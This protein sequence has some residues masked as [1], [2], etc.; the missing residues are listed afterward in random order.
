MLLSILFFA[1]AMASTPECGVQMQNLPTDLAKLG[2]SI[3]GNFTLPPLNIGEGFIYADDDG[4]VYYQTK[5]KKSVIV[6]DFIPI[7]SVVVLN[8]RVYL[9][10][11]LGKMAAFNLVAGNLVNTTNIPPA[12]PEDKANIMIP[13]RKHQGRPDGVIIGMMSGKVVF[14]SD[15]GGNPQVIE[16]GSNQNSGASA[17]RVSGNEILVYNSSTNRITTYDQTFKKKQDTPLDK[18]GLLIS[19]LLS[20][21][22]VVDTA[23][24]A[25]RSINTSGHVTSETVFEP[26]G[27]I[28]TPPAQ[29]FLERF[30]K[31][32]DYLATFDLEGNLKVYDFKKSANAWQ[33]A[34]RI[35]KTSP[36]STEKLSTKKKTP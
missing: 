26:I 21:K 12:R 9:L 1:F 13:L 36:Q 23:A 24:G 11:R 3:K 6:E 35:C 14:L 16:E 19:K 31:H 10:D 20:D 18:G 5:D 17:V 27:D 25:L 22:S 7:Q 30:N 28:Q 33:M 2:K 8:N 29:I 32:D 34:E 15:R 4:K